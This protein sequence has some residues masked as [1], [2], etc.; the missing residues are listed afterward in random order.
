[1]MNGIILSIFLP[2][3][4][5]AM[6]TNRV[7]SPQTSATYGEQSITE[8][9]SVITLPAASKTLSPLTRTSETT[10]LNAL[11]L[12]RSPTALPA[13]ESPMIATVGPMTTAGI[14]LLSHSTPANLITIAMMTYT[15]PAIAPRISPRYPS[16]MDMPPAKAALIDP[17]NANE[18]PRN[19]G[20]RNLVKSR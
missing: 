5:Q 19:T 16:C 7:T 12:E 14:S 4:E 10:S 3:T 18:L 1:M 2:Y 15:S 17:R 6:V 13:S 20:L 9:V 8:F 11:P